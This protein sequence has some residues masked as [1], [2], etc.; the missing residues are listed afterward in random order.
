VQTVV[1]AEGIVEVDLAPA[2][3]VLAQSESWSAVTDEPTIQA[4]ER[5][6]VTGVEGNTLSV[7]RAK[8]QQERQ[9]GA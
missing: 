8:S 3:I 2:G 9:E 7:R 4:G 6:V 1:G 5:V